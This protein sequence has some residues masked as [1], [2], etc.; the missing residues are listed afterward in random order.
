MRRLVQACI[1]EAFDL[2][3]PANEWSP[4][5]VT[6]GSFYG[7]E[8]RRNVVTSETRS[9]YGNGDAPDTTFEVK[10]AHVNHYKVDVVAVIKAEDL[11]FVPVAV[12]R[13]I[14]LEKFKF[15]PCVTDQ[16]LVIHSTCSITISLSIYT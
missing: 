12:K 9:L 8:R 1:N 3:S 5:V 13:P 14:I 7:H 4:N 16:M 2:L 11:G 6:R 15:E 10:R